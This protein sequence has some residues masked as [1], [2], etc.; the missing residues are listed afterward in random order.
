MTD[1]VLRQFFA[2]PGLM[3]PDRPTIEVALEELLAEGVLAEEFPRD[4]NAAAGARL[5]HA[6]FYSAKAEW[7]R[8]GPHVVPFDLT[9]RVRDDVRVILRG[10]R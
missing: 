10:L 7:L 4:M 2:E 6:A 1:I 9:A 3:G 5:L 8:P